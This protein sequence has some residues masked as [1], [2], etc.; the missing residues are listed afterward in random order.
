[1]EALTGPA[2]VSW[3]VEL[4]GRPRNVGCPSVPPA[5]TGVRVV[6]GSCPERKPEPLAGLRVVGWLSLGENDSCYAG[7]CEGSKSPLGCLWKSWVQNAHHLNIK[8]TTWFLDP[9]LPF[10]HM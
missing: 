4:R 6:K 10:P 8:Q 5:A 1:M 3:E 9:G 7:T 2:A